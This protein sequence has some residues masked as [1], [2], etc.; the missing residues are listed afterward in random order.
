MLYLFSVMFDFFGVALVIPPPL[1]HG[2]LWVNVG[3]G[4]KDQCFVH[5]L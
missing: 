5:Q 4:F 3:W 1:I 2:H